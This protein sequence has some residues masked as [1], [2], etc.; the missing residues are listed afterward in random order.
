[1]IGKCVRALLLLVALLF[2]TPVL[3]QSLDN[4]EDKI[5]AIKMDENYIGGEGKSDSRDK[6][7]E[8]ALGDL[9]V[10]VN[11]MRAEKGMGALE[12]SDI[13]SGLQELSYRNGQEYTV[14]VYISKDTV[15]AVAARVVTALDSE[16]KILCGQ[17]EWMEVRGLMLQYKKAGKIKETGNVQTFGEVPAD[18]YAILI[19]ARGGIL[20][21]LSPDKGQ[22]R[23]N[24]KTN[25]TDNVSNYPNS[26]FFVW[27]R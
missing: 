27:Y 19:D 24:C 22:G 6:A 5:D 9:L 4:V 17:G 23:T 12:K 16:T 11:E 10:T 15:M 7:K 14:F 1:M 20:S 8:Y 3:A 13:L 18:A 21:I 25:K 2:S 26:K